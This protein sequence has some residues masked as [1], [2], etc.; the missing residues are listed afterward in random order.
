MHEIRSL[1]GLLG[2]LPHLLATG[3]G[4]LHP[5]TRGGRIFCCF[6]ALAGVCVLGIALGIIGSKIIES[7]VETFEKA[8]QR[9]TTKVFG[10]FS[11][12]QNPR[13]LNRSE[14]SGSFSY[15]SDCDKPSFHEEDEPKWK[16]FTTFWR[17]LCVLLL[18]YTPALTPLFIG[19]FFMSRYE[20]W[21]L[22]ETVY[23]MVVTSTTIGYGDYVPER[24]S[25]KLFAVLYIPLA[26]GAMGHFLGT[27]AN[28]IIDE[29]RKKF[30][31]KLWK[32]E[33]T[34]EDLT[35]MDENEDG[36]VTEVEFLVFML[37]AM[38]KVDKELTDRIRDHFYHLD[39]TNN[40]VLARA[41]LELMARKKLRT[42][43]S[44]LRLAQYK[45][46]NS[47]RAVYS[48]LIMLFPFTH[49]IFLLLTGETVFV[50]RRFSS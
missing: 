19:A 36:Y 34:L 15:L 43:R 42:A 6:F 26:V 3:Y 25:T 33:I 1:E 31:K 48:V 37:V 27:I 24:Q 11:R 49:F 35:D 46:R 22:D 28:F 39:V 16:Q 14:S 23:Y 29:R 5:T 17:S 9:M 4:D 12:D 32:H 40:G 47:A 45:V 18:R 2:H 44:K 50:L 13:A 21:K 7:E 41:D 10:I 8:E 20:G 38:K 30:D